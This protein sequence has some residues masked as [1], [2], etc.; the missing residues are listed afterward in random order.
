[1]GV[2]V[3]NDEELGLSS[4]VS[5]DAGHAGDLFYYT[6]IFGHYKMLNSICPSSLN[7]N[8]FHEWYDFDEYVNS[9][10]MTGTHDSIHEMHGL[11]ISLK[12]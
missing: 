6:Y 4:S 3:S 12:Q 10:N 9:N 8:I 5:L 1:M 11:R 7:V 2:N